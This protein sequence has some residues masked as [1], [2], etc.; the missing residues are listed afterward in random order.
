MGCR[1]GEDVI[2]GHGPLLQHLESGGFCVLPD[3]AGLHG[4]PDFVKNR[5]VVNGGWNGHVVL[6][7]KLPDGL[8]EDF[9]GACLGQALDN[10][11]LPEAG[12]GA[13]FFVDDAH[14]FLLHLCLIQ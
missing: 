6:H 12:D 14:Q 11:G 1:R 10:G 4:L 3:A 2:R 8:A 9:P 13:N 7:G 5:R